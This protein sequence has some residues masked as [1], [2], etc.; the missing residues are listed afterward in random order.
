MADL[1]L[2]LDNFLMPPK[3][4]VIIEPKGKKG[5]SRVLLD[6]LRQQYL[7]GRII[8]VATEGEDLKAQAQVIPLM[9]HKSIMN[10]KPTV[11]VCENKTCQAPTDDPEIFAGQLVE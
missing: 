11:Y 9:N 8:A 4:I 10:H 5:S 6:K 2:A 3:E 7:P 1:Q